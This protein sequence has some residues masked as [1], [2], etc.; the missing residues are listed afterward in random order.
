MRPS[1]VVHLPYPLIRLTAPPTP[2][3]K[4]YYLSTHHTTIA[5][6]INQPFRFLSSSSLPKKLKVL[7][8]KNHQRLPELDTQ[9]PGTFSI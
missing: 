6:P 8:A 9:K 2:A 4:L 7:A 5:K 3:A 1:G